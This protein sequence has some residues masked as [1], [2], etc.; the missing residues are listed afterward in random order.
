MQQD[1]INIF[2]GTGV[3]DARV[4]SQFTLQWVHLPGWLLFDAKARIAL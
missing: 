2:E 3:L 4:S 1:T